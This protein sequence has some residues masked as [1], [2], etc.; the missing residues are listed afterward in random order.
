MTIRPWASPRMESPLAAH[1]LLEALDLVCKPSPWCL[2]LPALVSHWAGL[3][4]LE[5]PRAPFWAL[6]SPVPVSV[7]LP[8]FYL[9]LKK[10]TP[11]P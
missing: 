10:G 3:A 1:W 5:G 8:A 2:A 11:G 9:R 7:L 4:K 6:P